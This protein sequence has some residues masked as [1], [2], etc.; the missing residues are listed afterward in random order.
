MKDFITGVRCYLDVHSFI[1]KN[2]LTHY[3][4]IPG[5]ISILYLT[6]IIILGFV[7]LGLVADYIMKNWLPGYLHGNIME[8]FLLI[9]LWILLLLLLFITY[10]HVVLALLAPVLTLLSEKTECRVTGGAAVPFQLKQ[11]LI[12]LIRGIRINLR[13]MILSIFFSLAAW[14]LVLIPVIG[15]FLSLVVSF[16][17]QSYYGGFALVD[18]TLE[19]RRLSVR[20]S[21][22][23]VK[24]RRA[25][26]TGI[27]AG[28]FL[29]SLIPLIGWFLAPTYGTVA[30]TLMILEKK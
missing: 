27:G 12:D 21:I 19:R 11:A 28:F 7:Y 3:L 13:I 16:Y 15:A 18:Y 25:W 1:S 8:L 5:L 4:L 22:A 20:E 26:I 23:F 9:L 17:I 10:R 2:R 24:Q 6:I 30:A 14:L 29:L